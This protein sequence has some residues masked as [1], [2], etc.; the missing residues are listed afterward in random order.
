VVSNS[1]PI[2][3]SINRLFPV[4]PSF[5]V[6]D[7]VR[8]PYATAHVLPESQRALQ[9]AV[10]FDRRST[11][12]QL[13]SEKVRVTLYGVRNDTA[14]DYVKEVNLFTILKEAMGVMNMPVVRDE[15]RTQSELTVIAMK[16]SV[17][18]EINYYQRRVNDLARQLILKVIPSYTFGV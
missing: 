13:V 15:K 14:L 5:L 1:L 4:F 12:T 10:H 11:G 18:F 6:P 9:G 17:E 8:P 7:N 16:K 3:L 2:W